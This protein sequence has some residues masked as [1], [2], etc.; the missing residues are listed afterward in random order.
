MNSKIRYIKKL[1]VALAI[2]FTVVAVAISFFNKT[3]ISELAKKAEKKL[4][5]KEIVAKQ[6]LSEAV[7][8]LQNTP[9]KQLFTHFNTTYQNLYE[10]EGIILCLYKKDSLCYW[11]A[12]QPAIETLPF[13]QIN[14]TELIKIRNGW[15]VSILQKDSLP[16]QYQ[17]VALIAIKNQYDVE[18][19]YVN[20]NFSEWLELPEKT[21]LGI[22]FKNKEAIVRVSDGTILFEIQRSEPFYIN[23]TLSIIGSVCGFIAFGLLMYLLLQFIFGTVKNKITRVFVFV[24]MTLVIRTGMIYFKFPALFYE[25]GLFDPLIFANGSSFY[26]SYL[27][28]VVLNSFLLL[29]IAVLSYKTR[30]MRQF[31]K[32]LQIVLVIILGTIFQVYFSESMRQ[33]IY[34]LVNNSTITY[35]INDLFNLSIYTF[36]GLL[37][38]SFM[39][40]AFYLFSQELILL[41]LSQPNYK[42]V[43]LVIIVIVFLTF[44]PLQNVS[45]IEYSWS[46]PLV[47]LTMLLSKY[48]AS[49]NFINIGLIVLVGTLVTSLLFNQY[50]K[51]N[52]QKTYDALSFTLTDRQDVIAENEFVKVSKSIKSDERLKNLLLLLP[53][54]A[55]Q[56]EQSIRQTNFSGYFERYDIVLS[57]FNEDC[58]FIF[59]Q[60]QKQ[61][62]NDGYF[63]EEIKTGS[64]TISNELVFIDRENKPIKYVAKIEVLD[65]AD[66]KYKLYIQ[67]E[68]KNSTYLGVFPDLL[69]DK[70]LEK[71][72]ELKNT[73]YAIYYNNQLQQSFGDYL[74]PLFIKES[75]TKSLNSVQH[76]HSIYDTKNNTKLIIT[77]Q[78]LG[79]WQQI[80]SI[81]YLF[82]F[83]TAVVLISIWISN[84]TQKKEPKFQ[85]LN[86]RIQFIL[87]VVVFMSLAT[88]VTGTIGVVNTQFENKNKNELISKS[89]LVLNELQQY[90][91]KTGKLEPATKEATTLLLKK[92]AQL[93]S[94][95]ISIFTNKG[96]LYASS[97]SAIYDQGL[98]SKFMNP[99]AFMNFNKEALAA[100]SQRENIGALN[101]LSAYTPFYNNNAELVGFI[102]LPY[103][104]RQKDLENDLTAYLTTLINIYTLLFV[105]ATLVSLLLSNLLTKPLRII[106]QQLSKIK[107][108]AQNQ[109]IKWNS[110]DEI[111]GLVSEYNSMLVKLDSSLKR[112]AQSERESAW[113]EMAKQVAHEIKNPLTPMKLNIQHMK[114]VVATNPEDANERIAKVADMLIEQIDTLSHIATEFSNF[115]KLPTTQLEKIN[116]CDILNH[117]TQL[118]QQNTSCSIT[119]NKPN[120]L[121]IMADKEQCIRL[122]TNL[123]KNAEQAIPDDRAGQIDIEALVK[124]NTIYV[125]IK[126]NG[127]GMADHIKEKLFT[128]NFTTKNT[129][130][131]LGLAM[132]KNSVI[133]FSGS[134]SFET[135]ENKGT[136][137]T[138][139]FPMLEE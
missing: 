39:L 67:L 5:Q 57:L 90:I 2:F 92:L 19:K 42:L 110:N 12:N 4:H 8:A 114:R 84:L 98:I 3:P 29:L 89:H 115:A 113:R 35:N 107:F 136:T 91:G 109:E 82:I 11:T 9:T 130:T 81:S 132:V 86:Y 129:G 137:F 52:K 49:Y 46:V 32:P 36:I 104:S 50:E 70:S 123:L 126:D 62:L 102:N 53:Q 31:T 112:L 59:P 96:K 34:S 65:R 138:L 122:F 22:D 120:S 133:A 15:F 117:V 71:K 95:D 74:Y 1:P 18:N 14:N 55:Q 125:T 108:G 60:E 16:S 68:P 139:T 51:N 44:Y 121:W 75:F 80:A 61:Y 127:M 40:Y 101:Y 43:A 106:K 48:K 47:L 7:R 111:G 79:F 20:N 21:N 105:V 28:D 118:F 72:R 78:T 88:V 134:I 64:Q 33:L 85:S 27:G 97:Q 25:T 23:E 56:T 76:L 93:F 38:I 10:E 100:Y 77:S 6:K 128:P 124:E 103:F 58:V 17:A 54:S 66:K 87:V 99:I 30:F 26:F 73:S 69:L 131:G 94:S 63:D 13:S 41:V 37:S 83:F 24:F 116:L 135:I 45:L 119:L